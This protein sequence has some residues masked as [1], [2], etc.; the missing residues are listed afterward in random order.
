LRKLNNLLLGKLNVIVFLEVVLKWHSNSAAGTRELE[1]PTAIP[2]PRITKYLHELPA[3]RCPAREPLPKFPGEIRKHSPE[4]PFRFDPLT[5]PYHGA[6]S[7]SY[8]YGGYETPRSPKITTTFAQDSC[9]DGSSSTPSSYYQTP[10]TGSI[11]DSA[12]LLSGRTT[13]R[14]PKSPCQFVFRVV[15]RTSL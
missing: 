10:P 13:A 6:P 15:R 9:D 5:R 3:I 1:D 2:T 14:S 4:K 12:S 11:D 7:P 8:G